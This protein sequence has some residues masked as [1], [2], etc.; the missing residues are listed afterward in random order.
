MK[1]YE[2]G[3]FGWFWDENSP[4]PYFGE[5]TDIEAPIVTFA[6]GEVSEDGMPL[7]SSRLNRIDVASVYYDHWQRVESGLPE[8]MKGGSHEG[9]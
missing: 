5:L 9:V 4:R 2:I 1:N 7:F 3:T 6:T 8:Y